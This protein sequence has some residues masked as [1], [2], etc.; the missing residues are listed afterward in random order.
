MRISNLLL[1]VVTVVVLNPRIN[2]E[3][4]SLKPQ[5]IISCSTGWSLQWG[6]GLVGIYSLD[7]AAQLMS[8]RPIVVENSLNKDNFSRRRGYQLARDQLLKGCN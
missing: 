8:T 1:L 7:S 3:S 6:E 5:F 4:R 2:F